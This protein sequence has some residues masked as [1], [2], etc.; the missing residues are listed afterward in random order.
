MMNYIVEIPIA[1]DIL[2]AATHRCL[3]GYAPGFVDFTR[4]QLTF[5]SVIYHLRQW[6]LGALGSI[7]LHKIHAEV[8]DLHVNGPPT[9][10]DDEA[11]QYVARTRLAGKVELFEG[12]NNL[13]KSG[14]PAW[15]VALVIYEF[16]PP[17]KAAQRH[18]DDGA[19]TWYLALPRNESRPL[20]ARLHKILGEARKTLHDKRKEHHLLVLEAFDKRL[21]DDGFMTVAKRLA[22][23]MSAAP[24]PSQLK[25]FPSAGR[26]PPQPAKDASREEWFAYKRA[27]GRKFTHKDL[28][29][30][31]GLDDEYVRQLYAAWL[32]GID[33]ETSQNT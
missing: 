5:G 29:A 26:L 3:P 22:P 4:E 17:E 13:I 21:H 27:M 12:V 6:Q 18:G 31:L 2:D 14:A 24:K 16:V 7:E 33:D 19:T 28:A 30:V 9:P 25:Q 10:E 1:I 11:V 15:L 20:F 23:H 32:A 8:T